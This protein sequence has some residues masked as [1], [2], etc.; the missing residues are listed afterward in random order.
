MTTTNSNHDSYAGSAADQIAK[1]LIITAMRAILAID[2]K[3]VPTIHAVGLR[4]IEH[5]RRLM[6][7]AEA[8]QQGFAADPEAAP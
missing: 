1:D 2:R 4:L 3:D 5:G 8:R 7:F 6:A